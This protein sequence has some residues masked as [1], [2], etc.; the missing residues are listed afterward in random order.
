MTHPPLILV[1]SGTVPNP[2]SPRRNLSVLYG[3]ALMQAGLLGACML[4]GNAQMLA[5]RFDG[6]LLSGGGDI[7]ASLFGQAEHPEA[8]K[9]D[10]A[11]DHEELALLDAF[12]ACGKPVFGICR[13]MQV[14]NV[15]FGGDL[16]QHMTGHDGTPHT[17][18][19]VPGSRMHALCGASFTA[20]SFHHQAVDRLGDG[21]LGTAYAEDGTVEAIAH[22]TLPVYG[23]QWHPERMVRG[24]C[25]DTDA[26]HTALFS[27]LQAGAA[28]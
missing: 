3:G 11:R 5:G 23:V 6:L 12:C 14:L 9:P 21:L 1:S 10:L 17:I 24:L 13:G 15:Y 19:A 4:G 2:M 26:D 18:T 16:I 25:M 20:N 27:L 28:R 22:E 7:E 8:G